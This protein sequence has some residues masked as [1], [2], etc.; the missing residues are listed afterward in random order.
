MSKTSFTKEEILNQLT[1]EE[2]RQRAPLDLPIIL[3]LK[4]WNHSA[5]AADK[6]PSPG[7]TFHLIT[8]V[9]MSGKSSLYKPTL[10]PHIH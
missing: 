1:D 4:E 9:L 10:A 7:E 3:R 2:L 8:D 5:P 6:L